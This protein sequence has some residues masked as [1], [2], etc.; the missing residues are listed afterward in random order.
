MR[1]LKRR[2]RKL[3]K[4]VVYLFSLF[5]LLQSCATV[6]KYDVQ[7]IDEKKPQISEVLKEGVPERFLKRKVAIG[8]FTNETKYG[9]SFLIDENND[10]IGKQAMDILS[11][12]LA[13]T[14]KFILLE[15]AD[16]EM[17]NKELEM[18]NIGNTKVNADYLILGSISEFGRKTVGEVGFFSR[19]KKQLAYA[20]V[21]VRLIDIYS[22]Q[23]IY[24]EEA[25]GEAFSEAGT[26]LGVGARA[27]YDSSLNDKVIS[28]AISKLVNNIVENL[29]DKP[30]RSYILSYE[31]GNYIIAGG[32]TQGIEEND[33]FGVDKR[34]K[35]V[36]NPQTN[37][38]IELPG[39]LV[40]KIKVA[41][42]L[43]STL[44]EEITLCT[45]ERGQIPLT[46][47]ADLYIQEI[48]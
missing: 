36:K 26:V 46:D 37:M 29:L 25:E 9:Q 24:S 20:K 38:F 45:A 17:I 18:G 12:K 19:T 7:V 40:G 43:G 16:I 5:V 28:A 23:I 34:G 11:A 42:L 33:I 44:A 15:R 3:N 22:G 10:R 30:W 2:R 48:E 31:D 6:E 14:E 4:C 27:G 13:A 8:R 1:F 21:N 47:F 39:K 35:R 41:Q 32:K